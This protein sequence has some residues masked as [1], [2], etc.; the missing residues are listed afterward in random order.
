MKYLNNMEIKEIVYVYTDCLS[1]DHIGDFV[2]CMDC[3]TLMLMQLGG[4]ACGECESEN[5]E[6]IDGNKQEWSCEEVES[7][8]YIIVEK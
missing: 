7:A 1:S 6:W 4:T 2:R 3:G 8:G 5:L